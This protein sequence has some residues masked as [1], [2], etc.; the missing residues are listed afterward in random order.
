MGKYKNINENK[1]TWVTSQE[2]SLVIVIGRLILVFW[3]LLSVVK[4]EGDV[5]AKIV[6]IILIG[7]K[8][9]YPQNGAILW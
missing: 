5:L 4:K 8:N 2:V 1:T 9:G 7:P 3:I 6:D